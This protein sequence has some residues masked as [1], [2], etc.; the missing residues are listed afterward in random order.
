MRCSTI[1]CTW[2][3]EDVRAVT[4]SALRHRLLLNFDAE[5]ERVDTDAIL[6]RILERVPEPR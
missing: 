2:P 4:L 1:A 3:R 6:T 5:A